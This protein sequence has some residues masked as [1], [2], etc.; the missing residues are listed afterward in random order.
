MIDSTTVM[1]KL[2]LSSPVETEASG[3]QADTE[4]FERILRQLRE[5]KDEQSGSKENA[6]HQ[7]SQGQ[8]PVLEN[9]KAV[10]SD[11]IEG[12]EGKIVVS[13]GKLS[14]EKNNKEV[15]AQSGI[16]IS[17]TYL[18]DEQE[19]RIFNSQLETSV[20][21]WL[22]PP[23]VES[24]AL[25]LVSSSLMTLQDFSALLEQGWQPKSLSGDKVWRFSLQDSELS[26]AQIVLKAGHGAN[27]C[28][29]LGLMFN[30]NDKKV[31]SLHLSQLRARLEKLG[32]NVEQIA[33]SHE[34]L[35]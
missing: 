19:L 7:A 21:Q 26:L 27:G 5:P 16:A 2:A 30:G 24:S 18:S 33:V 15:G 1:P 32:N 10:S 4:D 8:C 29:S 3:R 17:E 35:T 12:I 28:W 34:N 20:A 14:L 31:L 22:P 11:D 6:E 23:G 25:S 9:R 13:E